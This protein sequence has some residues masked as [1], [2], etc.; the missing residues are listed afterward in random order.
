MPLLSVLSV[1]TRP[2]KAQEYEALAADLAQQARDTGES[3]HWTAQQVSMGG[4]GVLYFASQVA[5]LQGNLRARPDSRNGGSC[6]R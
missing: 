1:R 6:T 3:F 2:E 4:V 5:G